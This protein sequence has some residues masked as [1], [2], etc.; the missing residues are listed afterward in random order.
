[1]QLVGA[2]LDRYERLHDSDDLYEA[3]QWLDRG[4]PA[5]PY[6]DSL[7]ATRVFDRHCDHKVLRWHWMCDRGE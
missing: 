1:M 6:Q 3:M 7:L 4:W 2:L 5:I